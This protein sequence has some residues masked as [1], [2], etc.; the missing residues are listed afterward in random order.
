MSDLKQSEQQLGKW[1]GTFQDPHNVEHGNL[2][3]G[4]YCD[5]KRMEF[6]EIAQVDEEHRRLEYCW[7]EIKQKLNVIQNEPQNDTSPK[8]E[9]ESHIFL[10]TYAPLKHEMQ[11]KLSDNIDEN[12]FGNDNENDN[13]ND[14]HNENENVINLHKFDN[15]LYS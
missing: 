2:R 5:T 9:N 15:K 12:L 13:E 14:N 7:E 8:N 3:T 4:I 6:I 11:P 10:D 1:V